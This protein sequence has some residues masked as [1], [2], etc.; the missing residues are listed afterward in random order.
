MLRKPQGGNTAADHH[1]ELLPSAGRE[2]GA[3]RPQNPGGRRFLM[4]VLFVAVGSSRPASEQLIP[5]VA[6]R[7]EN[8]GAESQLNIAKLK[9]LHLTQNFVVQQD[10]NGSM[11]RHDL[12]FWSSEGRHRA[13]AAGLLRPDRDHQGGKGQGK[14]CYFHARMDKGKKK[15]WIY[16]D[17]STGLPKGDATVSYEDPNGASGAVKWFNNKP[18]ENNGD[19]IQVQSALSWHV[20][21]VRCPAL[22]CVRLLS[23]LHR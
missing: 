7:C 21:A 17:K 8:E 1:H 15:V 13:T 6:E 4:V 20:F 23:G 5:V 19:P 9:I 12:R 16:K 2:K 10:V 18:F 14:L 3:Q 11:G 22:T